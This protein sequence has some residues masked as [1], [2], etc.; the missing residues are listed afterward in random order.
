MIGKFAA[1]AVG[2]IFVFSSIALVF[3]ALARR[4]IP[5][6]LSSLSLYSMASFVSLCVPSPFQR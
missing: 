1:A 5:A 2:F 4:E 6:S 3:L